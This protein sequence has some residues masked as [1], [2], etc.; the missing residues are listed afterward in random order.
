VSKVGGRREE[1]TGR[2]VGVGRVNEDGRASEEAVYRL[3]CGRHFLSI[4]FSE[5]SARQEVKFLDVR[6]TMRLTNLPR[7]TLT[8]INKLRDFFRE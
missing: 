4:V 1:S 8:K 6:M 5:I 2:E 3:G 7:R